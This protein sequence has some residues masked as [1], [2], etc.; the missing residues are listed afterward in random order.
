MVCLWKFYEKL[1]RISALLSLCMC[2]Q[3]RG[4]SDASAHKVTMICKV[5][6]KKRGCCMGFAISGS[7]HGTTCSDHYITIWWGTRDRRDFYFRSRYF[8]FRPG[9]NPWFFSVNFRAYGDLQTTSTRMRS[10]PHARGRGQQ[11]CF[12]S[13]KFRFWSVGNR[14]RAWHG[15]RPTGGGWKTCGINTRS[16][17][18]T[19]ILQIA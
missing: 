14:A 18:L 10:Q 16:A 12:R 2:L 4:D 3:P 1:Q 11:Y 15:S 8:R 17:V 7:C 5:L 6:V 13:V 9:C 19:G